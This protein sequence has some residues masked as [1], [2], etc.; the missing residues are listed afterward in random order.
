MA[1][2]ISADSNAS[3]HYLHSG[4]SSTITSSYTSPS[5]GPRGITWTNTSNVISADMVADLHYLHSGVSSTIT[6]SYASPS[7]LPTGITWDGANVMSVDWDSDLHYLHSGF[8]STIS[9]S[10]AT[11]GFSP[12]GI[13]WDGSNVISVDL[14]TNT[15]YLHSGFSSTIS[16]SYASPSSNPTGIAWDS[17][18]VISADNYSDTHYLHSGFSS[19]V[20]SSYS[21]PSTSPRGITWDERWMLSSSGTIAVV[22]ALVGDALYAPS[23]MGVIAVV[24][25]LVGT[26]AYVT[27]FDLSIVAPTSGVYLAS[28]EADFTSTV[29]HVDG[30]DV[31][32]LWEMDTADPPASANADYIFQPTGYQPHDTDVTT[33]VEDM[34]QGTWYTRVQ[35]TD[36]TSTTAWTDTVMFYVMRAIS[37]IRGSGVNKTVLDA[38]NKVYVVVDGTAIEETATYDPA[39]EPLAYSESPREALVSLKAGDATTAAS[40][41]ATHLAFRQ[42]PREYLTGLKVPIEYGLGIQRDRMIAVIHSSSGINGNYVVRR[43]QHDFSA[44]ETTIEVGDF[45]WAPRDDKDLLV[46]LAQRIQQMGKEL[47]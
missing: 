21:S 10:H 34:T 28:S 42:R 43:I 33:T 24:S 40:V 7:T 1:N 11:P 29:F 18:N 27:S 32:Y 14:S 19:T 9:S 20:T 23:A 30:L 38:A 35:A 2:V 16:D 45:D 44:G 47:G 26:A 41:A 13:T 22:S 6:S 46:R 15:H 5:T 39:G 3:L 4:F 37:L 31:R 12:S 36:G 8:S 17:L 25:A